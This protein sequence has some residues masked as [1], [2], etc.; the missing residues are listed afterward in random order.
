M[1][2]IPERLGRFQH[3]AR[4]VRLPLFMPV[5]QPRSPTFRLALWQSDP[6]I[7][8]CIVNAFFLYK[9]REIRKALL[10]SGSL[11][12]HIG[13]QGL[14]TTDS[15]AFQGFTRPLFL[16]NRDI[17]RFQ[18]R[19]GSDVLAPLDLVTPPG[20]GRTEAT[21][22]LESTQKRILEALEIAENSVVAGV[23]QGGRFLDLRQRSVDELARAGIEYLAIGSLVPFFNKNH[24]MRFVAAVLRGA[25]KTIGG[26][27]P[28]HVYGAGD[29]CEL[30]FLYKLGADIFDS[31]S[32]AHFAK[33]GWYMTP[34][35][36]IRDAGPLVAGEYR[37]E[38]P[39]C[40]D[41]AEVRDVFEDEELLTRHNLWTICAT[42]EALRSLEN[43][44]ALDDMLARILEVHKAWFPTSELPKTWTLSQSAES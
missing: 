32:Y 12:D 16:K 23:Q 19:I 36:A 10:E 24:D 31:S 18:D 43:E 38:C 26:D 13:F 4:S 33:D 1:T 29:P 42:V 7:D 21:K 37:C 30:P 3:R 28:I 35:G 9:Q 44:R 15:G 5:Y 40:T 27:V 6:P 14:V 39:V 17:V 41:A 11:H 25:R 22:K 20:N 34:Y 2:P 8:A